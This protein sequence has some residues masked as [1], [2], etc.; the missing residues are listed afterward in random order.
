MGKKWN[1]YNNVPILYILDMFRHLTI[2]IFKF[3]HVLEIHVRLVISKQEKMFSQPEKKLC[4]KFHFL[5]NHRSIRKYTEAMN[6]YVLC[7]GLHD[8]IHTNVT[9]K[10][11]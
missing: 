4:T 11:F 6:K 1:I 2:Y 5:I 10:T 3:R 7:L 8:G 9:F